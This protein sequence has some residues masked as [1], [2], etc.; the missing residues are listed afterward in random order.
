MT[1][2][3]GHGGAQGLR[4]VLA[5][6]E[7]RGALRRIRRTVD[8]R[9]ELSAVLGHDDTGPAVLFENPGGHAI[10]RGC[11]RAE[12]PAERMARALGCTRDELP[13]R[14]V[15]ALRDPISPVIVDDPPHRTIT[16]GPSPDLTTLL[17]V[18]TWFEH[19]SGPYITAGVFVVKHPETGRRNVSIARIRVDGGN[20]IMVG[21]AKNHHLNVLAEAARDQG[22]T[23]PVAIAIGNHPAVM[24]ASQMYIGI[25]ED[26]FDIAGT[27]LGAPLRLTRCSTVDLEVPA[28]A[29][30]VLEGELDAADLGQR[31][32][33]LG[34]P[35]ILCQ[36]RPRYGR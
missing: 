30:I 20:R 35:R 27:L 4:A 16:H 21:A 9:F 11:P 18:P 7:A 14:L 33:S 24:L 36:L 32:E 6:L 22:R 23:L 13:D 3:D 2:A 8:L 26:E 5:D 1:G 10:A 34:V 28:E 15:A 29:E 17:P 31:G 25:G 12:P 19:E